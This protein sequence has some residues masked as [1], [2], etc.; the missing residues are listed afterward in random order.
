MKRNTRPPITLV[1]HFPRFGPYHLARINAAF[2]ELR[3][4]GVKVVGME[5]ASLD[6]TYAWQ[7]EEG[8]TAFE[9]RVALPG[10]VYERSS[11]LEMW[12]GV[13]SVLDSVNPDA[14]AIHGYS[15]CDTWSALA[16]CNLHHR[17]AILLSD[18]KYDDMPRH[19]C[20]EWLKQ[21]LVHKFDAALCAGRASRIYLERLGM[22]PEQIFEGFDVVDNDFFWRGAEKARRDPASYRSMPGLESPEPFFLVSARFI[23]EKNLDGLLRSYTQYRRV[24]SETDSGRSPWRL[25]ILG[26]GPERNALENLVRSEGIQGV[27]FPGFLQIDQLPIYYGLASFFVH[28]SHQDTWGLVV[29]EAMAA[30]LPILVSKNS[31]CAQDLVCEGENGFTFAS[32]DATTLADLMK[33]VSSGQANLKAM[34]V[35][36]RNRIKNWGLTRFAQGLHGALQAALQRNR[37]RRRSV[38]YA[39]TGRHLSS[40]DDGGMPYGDAD[41]N[42]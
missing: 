31:G 40:H 37:S 33:K 20:K 9:R 25:V 36:S 5:T 2:E 32:E 6:D 30:G 7:Q 24:L 10:R 12:R 38:R 41:G 21:W 26:D 16:W 17:K 29:N 18:S 14:M 11:R 3:T 13:K 23:H 42:H 19:F 27:S 35:S 39:I 15:T 8:A 22:E 34:S 1:V 4:A 28:P